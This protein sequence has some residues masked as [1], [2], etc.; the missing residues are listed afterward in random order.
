MVLVTTVNCGATLCDSVSQILPFL[1]PYPTF[2][3]YYIDYVLP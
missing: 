2:G 1:R 3:L